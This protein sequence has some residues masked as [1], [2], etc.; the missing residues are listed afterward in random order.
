MYMAGAPFMC[1]NTWQNYSL[2]QQ[3]YLKATVQRPMNGRIACSKLK[4]TSVAAVSEFRERMIC[5]QVEAW[6]GELLA[7]RIS[8]L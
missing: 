3:P 6:K 4:C 7:R 2:I 5:C 8:V 1:P